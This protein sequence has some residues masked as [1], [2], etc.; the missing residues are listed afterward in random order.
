M[1]V[2]YLSPRQCWPTQSGAKLRDY[3]LAKALGA[4]SALT[5]LYF[6]APDGPAQTAADLPF[7]AA[8]EGIPKPPTYSPVRLLRGAVG[9]TAFP[10]LNYA[11]AAM[12]DAVRRVA[13][14]VRFDVIHAD[15]IHMLHFAQLAQRI[16]GGRVIFNWHNIE[17]EAM[18]RF[19][20]TTPSAGRRWYARMTARKLARTEREI[21]HSG[22][23]HVVCSRREQEQLAALAPRARIAVAENGVDCAAFTPRG[24]H[25][26]GDVHLVF[27][28]S[29]DYFPNV[30]AAQHFVTTTWPAMRARFPAARL[31][32]VGANPT[33]A[34]R[35]LASVP[36]VTVTGTVPDVRPY[37]DGALASI[38]P[39]RTGGGTRLKILESMAIG[40]PVIS[41]V[42]GAEGIDVTDGETVLLADAATPAE[43]VAQVERLASDPAARRRMSAAVRTLA[44]ERYDWVQIGREM[45]RT[46]ADWL[47]AAR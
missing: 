15:S 36:G 6:A 35:A 20:E 38:V 5:Y 30:D 46:Y 42:I 7:C 18:A 25:V 13:A 23:G 8:L 37:Y 21:L 9:R 10:L 27:V 14:Q 17:S 32:I 47:G 26:P 3:H 28:G 43:W 2:L 39:L 34:V 22:F 12:D 24:A 19:A 4:G 40:T 29:M 16:G 33:E 11:S 1:N 31:S 44:S 41:T 45:V